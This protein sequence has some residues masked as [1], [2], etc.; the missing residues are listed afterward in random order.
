M[1]DVTREK[2]IEKA[3]AIN[4]I[5]GNPRQLLNDSEIGKIYE[6]VSKR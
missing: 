1:D 3:H 4:T 2:A 5:I 6:D